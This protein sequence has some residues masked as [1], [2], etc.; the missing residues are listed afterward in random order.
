MPHNLPLR[1]GFAGTSDFARVA[2]QLILEAGYE[3]AIVLTQPDRPAGRGMKLNPSPVKL[4]ALDH[5]ILLSQPQGL[6]LDGRFATDAALS[7]AALEK[8]KINVLIVAAYG[9]MVP[10]WLLHL[11]SLGCLNIHASLLPRWRGAAPIHRSIEAG[12]TLTGVCIMQMD[13]G[14]D[15]GDILL[16]E[17]MAINSQDSTGSL[18]DRLAILGGGL[19]I[20]A[21]QQAQTGQLS[22][23]P[24]A[25][26]G[27]TYAHKVTKAEA[28]IDWSAP[29]ARLER[30]I[31][32]F[33]PFPGA[34]TDVQ[35][36]LLKLWGAREVPLKRGGGIGQI[37]AVG[38]EGLQVVC[39]EGSAL[40]VTELQKPGGKRLT[41]AQFF[42]AQNP[43]DW[44]GQHMGLRP[45]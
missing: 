41:A 27:V 6:R 3:V 17:S 7:K 16:A 37:V 11:P 18:H 33:D 2:L 1:L 20:Q 14:L 38:P 22:P 34:H 39:G 31:R 43:H 40:E 28:L 19:I 36:E 23:T 42:Q 44:L 29:A 5:G 15:T 26:E 25:T 45:A 32:A 4:L 8:A 13:E 10:P 24:Q 21:L 30:Q 35:G 12:D 9:L